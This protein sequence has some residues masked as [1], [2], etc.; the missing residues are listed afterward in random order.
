[1]QDNSS[2]VPIRWIG[3]ASGPGEYRALTTVAD[4]AETLLVNWPDDQKGDTWRG[5]LAAC[6]R[7]LDSQIN[8]N[9]AREA[10]ILAARDANISLILDPA[11]LEPPGSTRPK[12]K[13]TWRPRAH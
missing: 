7:A 11:M 9:A 10:F 8:G 1:M 13:H 3:V 6:L 4:I 12:K 2:R 5:T